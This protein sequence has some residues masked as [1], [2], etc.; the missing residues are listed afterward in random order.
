[1]YDANVLASKL[2]TAGG[3][4]AEK[5]LITRDDTGTTTTYGQ[6][7]GNA[8]RS[9]ALLTELGV[10]AGDTVLVY[11]PKSVASL[12]LYFGCLLAGAVYTPIN[13]AIPMDDIAYFV[14]DAKPALIVSD[15]S[16]RAAC[17]GEAA[18]IPVLT[19][20]ENDSGSFI[21]RRDSLPTGFDA[22]P[23]AASDPAAILYTSGTT[24]R[25]KGVVH[26][27]AS[28]ASNAEVLVRT[29]D[30]SESD[31]LIHA[32]PIF[33]LHGLFT[34]MNVILSVGASCV[35]LPK[36]DRDRVLSLM[37]QATVMMGVP[38]FY[39][40]LLDAPN[41]TEATRNMRVCISGSAPML[42]QTHDAWKQATG[43][44]I[45]E[46]YGMT[47][48][49]MIAS[50][51]YDAE[52]RPNSVGFPLDGT[53]IRITDMKTGDTLPQ[54]DTGMIEI[55]GPN[56]FDGYY[57]KPEKTAEDMRDD[58]FFIS[59]DFGRYDADGYLYVLGRVKDAIFAE[60][61]VVMPKEVEELVDA[62]PGVAESAVISVKH[63]EKG[64]VPV[65]V[66]VGDAVNTSAVQSAL[67]DALPAHKVPEKYLTVDALP[68]NAM[69][70]VQ[71]AAL[72][73]TY[74]DLFAGDLVA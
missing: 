71:K 5:T 73:E 68:R 60:A 27:H 29:W 37:P 64:N 9:A 28:L 46:R 8:E 38:P 43:K 31:V 53:E 6:F 57:N 47:E 40:S 14:G 62:Q 74:A 10:T 19:I 32:L 54:G 18:G 21:D 44:M 20:N 65:A 39:M 66:I 7:F 45:L 11:A 63:P 72:R 13:P 4:R 17:E 22:C 34:A 50:N 58:G 30:F 35:F 26:S 69:G 15:E 61:G 49:S 70:K 36:F 23:R 51:P 33:H 25:P 42:P 1:M 3:S 52:R 41:L 59:G 24:G 16:R 48:C 2:A 56:L 55:R 12:E 67:R